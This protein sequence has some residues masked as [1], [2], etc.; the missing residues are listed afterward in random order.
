MK[1]KTC[2]HRESHHSRMGCH[3]FTNETCSCEKFIPS[4]S[5]L[6]PSVEVKGMLTDGEG[7]YYPNDSPS[8]DVWCSK[9][10]AVFPCFHCEEKKE[11]KG[12]EK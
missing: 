9:H 12:G 2:G 1:C 5:K 7:A 11:K 8:E 3:R 10:H 6:F 4:K